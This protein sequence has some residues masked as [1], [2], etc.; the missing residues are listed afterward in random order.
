M[1]L[2]TTFHFPGRYHLLRADGQG[3]VVGFLVRRLSEPPRA[4]VIHLDHPGLVMELD[5]PPTYA[6]RAGREVSD[7]GF[8]HPLVTNIM[9]APSLIYGISAFRLK[10]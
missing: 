9:P 7:L 6:P 10:A 5:I 3:R 2:E 1:N 4:M 8:F